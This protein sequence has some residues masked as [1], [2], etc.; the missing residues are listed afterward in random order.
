MVSPGAPE[1]VGGPP[2]GAGDEYLENDSTASSAD[3]SILDPALTRA[4]ALHPYGHELHLLYHGSTGAI[5]DYAPSPDA[6]PMDQAEDAVSIDAAKQQREQVKILRQRDHDLLCLFNNNFLHYYDAA[7]REA[8]YASLVNFLI[9]VAIP[10]TMDLDHFGPDL[11]YPTPALLFSSCM[12]W[13]FQACN[14]IAPNYPTHVSDLSGKEGSCGYVILEVLQA[15]TSGFGARAYLSEFLPFAGLSLAT[16]SPPARPTCM[17]PPS[18]STSSTTTSTPTV[19]SVPTGPTSS[20][21]LQGP[22]APAPSSHSRSWFQVASAPRPLRASDPAPTTTSPR[23]FTPKHGLFWVG[24]TGFNRIGFDT[25]YLKH[26]ASSHE[27]VYSLLDVVE[28]NQPRHRTFCFR[29]YHTH[30]LKDPH[31]N[32][33]APKEEG[34]LLGF[35]TLTLAQDFLFGK[36]KLLG[37]LP[38]FAYPY[39]GTVTLAHKGIT[40][41]AVSLKVAALLRRPPS[42]PR[43]NAATGAQPSSTTNGAAAASGDQSPST[44]AGAAAAP[45][46]AAPATDAQPSSTTSDTA[47]AIGDQPSSTTSGAATAT[48]SDDRPPLPV[49]PVRATEM[50]FFPFTLLLHNGETMEVSSAREALATDCF[51]RTGDFMSSTITPHGLLYSHGNNQYSVTPLESDP[52][53]W[54]AGTTGIPPAP[55]SP[56]HLDGV[57]N[58]PRER[59]PGSTPPRAP[60]QRQG[61][62]SQ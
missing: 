53:D 25:S 30:T 52:M 9:M 36:F 38:I 4:I 15:Y 49:F 6:D 3:R 57:T 27:G 19:P 54:G 7:L 2:P 37:N 26:A 10:I 16:T 18:G 44:N 59:D 50:P 58:G 28:M 48:T 14:I 5:R 17:D 45:A 20:S 31:M 13:Y 39:T 21:L 40:P 51:V 8:L 33:V 34:F 1:P 46:D 56:L 42:P 60:R 62:G 29:R 35:R 22:T 61:A 43:P 11:V 12:A 23:P 32:T 41:E 24:I 55:D 47:A